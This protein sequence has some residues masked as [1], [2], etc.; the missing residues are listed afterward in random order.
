MTPYS[1]TVRLARLFLIPEGEYGGRYL[2]ALKVIEH[3]AHRPHNG[4]FDET[5][6][7]NIIGVAGWIG[8]YEGWNRLEY[9]WR[10][11]LPPAAGGDF[12]YTDFWSRAP[13]NYGATWSE[14]KRLDHVKTLATIAHKCT[15]FAVGFVFNRSLFEDLI[16]ESART[17]LKTP[18]H[19]CFA[20]CLAMVLGS[21]SALSIVP[22]TPWDVM[23][24]R[25]REEQDSIGQIY[26]RT[27]SIFDP[28]QTIL[29]NIGFGE[30]KKMA[31]LQA[32]D[33][34]VGEL[35]RKQSGMKSEVLD[36]L[37]EKHPI[38]KAFPTD[39]EFREYITDVQR[40]IR[41]KSEL[42]KK[43]PGPVELL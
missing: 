22:P 18:L 1:E 40:R 16:P 34:L 19:F 5:E 29:G 33:L 36:L 9:E 32:A 7:D 28:D 25:K 13:G 12:H 8:S 17:F 6:K 41:E 15:S 37:K 11:A 10:Q 26:Y 38:I 35:R 27:C 3:S 31:A 42:G 23:F 2:M 4:Y 30:R 39:D 43:A 14:E 21:R 24:D 20:Q